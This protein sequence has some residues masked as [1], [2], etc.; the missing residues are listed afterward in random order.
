MGIHIFFDN[1]NVWGGAQNIRADKE[2][3]VPWFLLRIY[4]KNIFSLIEGER[5]VGTRVMAGSVPPECDQLWEYA[6]KLG[7]N[8]DLLIRVEDGARVRE[9]GV[10]ELLHL[11]MVNALVDFPAPQTLVV[12]SGDGAV[13][14]F[15]TSFITQIERALKVG[16][17]VE[18]WSWSKS[19][20]PKYYDLQN[21]N[22]DSVRI[23]I[24]DEYYDQVTF[25]K[26]GSYERDEGQFNVN[27]RIVSPLT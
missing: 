6:K 13:S 24:L 14:E 21:N 25:V 10:D 11:K 5:E 17:D 9:Q 12:V 3:S 16:W 18:V 23:N 26:A 15:D 4:Y 22:Q 19:L 20:N 7:Y 2:P 27:A 8:V 1:S